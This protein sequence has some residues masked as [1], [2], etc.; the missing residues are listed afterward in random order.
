MWAV[1]PKNSCIM[2]PHTENH[3]KSKSLQDGMLIL[4]ISRTIGI[5]SLIGF[6]RMSSE[7]ILDIGL[8]CE[9]I[10]WSTLIHLLLSWMQ[11]QSNYT[12]HRLLSLLKPNKSSLVLEE[13]LNFFLTLILILSSHPMISSVWKNHQVRFFEN[14]VIFISII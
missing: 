9:I 10:K 1:S 3:M 5:L 13:D 11:I 12:P 14:N 6:R 4:I 7:L 2:H 8:L